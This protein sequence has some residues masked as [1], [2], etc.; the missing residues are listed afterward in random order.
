M[1]YTATLVIFPAFALTFVEENA[2]ASRQGLR[3]TSTMKSIELTRTAVETDLEN[4]IQDK[5]PT[6]LTEENRHAAEALALTARKLK[7]FVTHPIVS[8]LFWVLFVA[9][10]MYLQSIWI[11]SRNPILLP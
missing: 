4:R 5:N 2:F 7:V 8:V 11:E 9:A 1:L 10:I 3:R 6:L